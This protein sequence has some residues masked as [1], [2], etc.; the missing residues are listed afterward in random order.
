MNKQPIQITARCPIRTTMEMLGG[1]WKLLI[2]FQLSKGPQRY[3]ELRKLIPDIS[4]KMLAQELRQLVV[5]NLII[6]RD[7]ATLPART[8]YQL[9][10]QGR[11]VLPIIE[12]MHTFSV[13]YT[14]EM[15]LTTP[16]CQEK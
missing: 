5:D 14:M 7:L 16:D 2:L 4:D 9:T 10:S 1:K 3:A 11:L 12:A 13:Q 8:E 6:R 15:Q